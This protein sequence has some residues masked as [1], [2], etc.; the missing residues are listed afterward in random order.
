M[1]VLR[2]KTRTDPFDKDISAT[3]PYSTVWQ[4][5]MFEAPVVWSAVTA[6]HTMV[7]QRGPRSGQSRTGHGARRRWRAASGENPSVLRSGSFKVNIVPCLGAEAQM[8]RGSL[9]GRVPVRRGRS[10]LGLQEGA[11]DGVNDK[12]RHACTRLP[13]QS[14]NVKGRH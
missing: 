9:P 13:R 2:H 1:L 7:A 8:H 12:G 11:V 4:Q 6:M 5:I 14:L 10:V 3:L